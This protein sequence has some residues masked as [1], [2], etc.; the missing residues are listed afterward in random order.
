ML[1]KR[2]FYGLLII[3]SFSFGFAQNEKGVFSDK[4]VY[5]SYTDKNFDIKANEI[6]YAVETWDETT[7]E[8]DNQQKFS[9]LMFYKGDYVATIEEVE[10]FLGMSCPPNQLVRKVTMNAIEKVLESSLPIAVPEFKNMQEETIFQKDEEDIIA[11]FIYSYKLGKAGQ[12]YIKIRQKIQDVLGLKILIVSID[13][14]YI[15]DIDDI[16]KTEIFMKN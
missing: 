13:G 12:S 10:Q 9:L 3:F 2:I 1:I 6:Y 8:E 4:E 7:E 16:S 11:V 15:S 5:L 14:A